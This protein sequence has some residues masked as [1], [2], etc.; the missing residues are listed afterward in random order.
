MSKER[1]EAKP[2]EKLRKEARTEAMNRFETRQGIGSQSLV[3][4]PTF[5]PP[6]TSLH[7]T[8]LTMSKNSTTIASGASKG[9]SN[10]KF[11]KCDNES[12]FVPAQH[13]VLGMQNLA[14]Q[15]NT[16]LFMDLTEEVDKPRDKKIKVSQCQ[17]KTD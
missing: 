13:R 3:S 11:K 15:A 17:T 1:D 16:S 2:T 8:N 12:P 7:S 4:A 10:E 5:A 9:G 6:K 14:K